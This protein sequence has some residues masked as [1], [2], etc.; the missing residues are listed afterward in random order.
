MSDHNLRP[1][2][3][4]SQISY[5]CIRIDTGT[6]IAPIFKDELHMLLSPKS[7]NLIL[8]Y[9]HRKESNVSGLGLR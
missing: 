6:D 5:E 4:F 9:L 7:L 2:L 1:D 3:P 8:Q